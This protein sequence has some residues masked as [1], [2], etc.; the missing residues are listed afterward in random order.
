M[1]GKSFREGLARLQVVGGA[2]AADALF[3]ELDV[4][5]RGTLDHSELAAAADRPRMGAAG[6]T[7]WG[8]AAAAAV[9]PAAGAYTRPLLGLT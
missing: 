8:H 6:S 7:V 5:R 2:A 4:K 3:Q 1:T 9:D